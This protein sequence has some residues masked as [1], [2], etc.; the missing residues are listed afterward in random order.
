[1][2]LNTDDPMELMVSV[3]FLILLT[4]SATIP[5]E[6]IPNDARAASTEYLRVIVAA[7]SHLLVNSTLYTI[8]PS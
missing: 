2:L 1:V 8:S 3:S 4:T 5:D 7:W 6:P